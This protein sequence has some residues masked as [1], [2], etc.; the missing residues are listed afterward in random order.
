M[1]LVDSSVWIDHLRKTDSSLT[2][3]LTGR[4][5]TMHPMVVGEV[6]CGNLQ[7]R[8][9][10]L[11]ELDRLPC[12]LIARHSEVMHL[13]ESKKLMGT[14]LGFVDIHILV[15]TITGSLKLWT[16]DKKLK[17]AAQRLGCAYQGLA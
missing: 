7:N 12:A 1:I 16:R 5:V 4:L 6:A 2:K 8:V 3:L 11:Q 9:G 14:G 10:I 15:A 17:Q 13:I